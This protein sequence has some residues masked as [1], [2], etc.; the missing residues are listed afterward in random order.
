MCT[1]GQH[2]GGSMSG[3]IPSYDNILYRPRLL[4]PAGLPEPVKQVLEI[5]KRALP[6][7]ALNEAS[8]PLLAIALPVTQMIAAPFVDSSAAIK[9]W[10][11]LRSGLEM[12]VVRLCVK[13]RDDP[14]VVSG[15]GLGARISRVV[16]EG[17]FTKTTSVENSISLDPQQG[18]PLFFLQ[19]ILQLVET[20]FTLL[21]Q[22][23]NTHKISKVL[24]SLVSVAYIASLYQQAPK[25]KALP[26]FIDGASQIWHISLAVQKVFAW[27]MTTSPYQKALVGVEIT[28]KVI[29]CF[30]RFAQAR[31]EWRTVMLETL[32]I[33]C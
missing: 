19:S 1:I 21:S 29:Y 18:T 10:L 14:I 4:I 11:L 13:Y 31:K 3:L 22:K 5:V 6:L 33:D 15:D 17:A 24:E 16:P 2:L 20:P 23:D 27:T 8:G 28:V 7:F 26:L 12:A 30:V 9:G 32:N 25:M